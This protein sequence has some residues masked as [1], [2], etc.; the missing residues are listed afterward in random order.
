[1]SYEAEP[2]VLLSG[3]AYV[4]SPRWHEDRLWFAHCGTGEIVAVGLDG[5]SEVVGQGPPGLGWSIDS[6]PTASRSPTACS[7]RPTTRRWSSPSPS[8]AASPRSTSPTTAAC[9][10]DGC[11]PTDSV[12]TASASTPTARCGPMPRTRAQHVTRRGSRGRV[13]PRPR[14]RRGA[15][16]D[17]ARPQR[18][19]LHARR[20][21]PP[22]TVHA[23]RRVGQASMTSTPRSPGGPARCSWRPRPHQAS[24]GPDPQTRSGHATSTPPS[25][26]N[27]MTLGRCAP[28]DAEGL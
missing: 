22:D 14:R 21:R 27:R 2:R 8:P 1:M 11:G 17:R 25:A 9:R 4:E 13:C 23:D 15:A 19:C 3:L 28:S 26:K 16:A 12:P 18:L 5:D 20:T 10:T 7:S 6:C 24:A